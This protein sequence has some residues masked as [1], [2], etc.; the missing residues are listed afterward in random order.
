MFIE[1]LRVSIPPP[2][3]HS[4][5][6]KNANIGVGE[7]VTHKPSFTKHCETSTHLKEQNR[8]ITNVLCNTHFVV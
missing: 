6:F 1:A 5:D 2:P 7:R 3:P 8:Y 4:N